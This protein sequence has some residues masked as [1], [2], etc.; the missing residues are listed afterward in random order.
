ML[1]RF[2]EES[3]DIT[4][5]KEDIK[6]MKVQDCMSY[7]G[8]EYINGIEI[9]NSLTNPESDYNKNSCV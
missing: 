2:N 8:I 7:L 1:T 6:E 4:V 9:V 5:K 3:V